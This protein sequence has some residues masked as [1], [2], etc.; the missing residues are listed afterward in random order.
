M[1]KKVMALFASSKTISYNSVFKM[2][3]VNETNMCDNLI[4]DIGD[5]IE[6]LVVAG[7]LRLEIDNNLRRVQ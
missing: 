1:T 2:L 5:A 3:G 4:D 6:C 7:H